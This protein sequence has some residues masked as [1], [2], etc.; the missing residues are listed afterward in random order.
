MQD[1]M[2]VLVLYNGETFYIWPE[3]IL[4]ITHHFKTIKDGDTC[5]ISC[6]DGKSYKIRKD[7]YSLS[8]I[9]RNHRRP[10]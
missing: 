10:T 9:L 3:T 4:T 6:A 7:A 2:L 1:E 5:T 8:C